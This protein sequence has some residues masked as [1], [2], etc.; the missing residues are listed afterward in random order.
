MEE[1]KKQASTIDE[2]ISGCPAEVQ[3]SLRLLR[4]LIREAAP[5]AEEKM[6]WQMPTFYLHGNLVHFAAQKSHIGLYPGPSGVEAFKGKTAEYLTSKGA[7]RLPYGKPLPLGLIEE[8]VR[9]R[10]RENLEEH[11]RKAGRK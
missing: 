3:D 10:V 1:K 2:Y 4:G 11:A 9:L 8:V 7:I 6:S 5:D